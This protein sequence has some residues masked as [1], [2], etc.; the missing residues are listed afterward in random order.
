MAETASRS[1]IDEQI[2]HYIETLLKNRIA[3][4]RLYLFGSRAKGMAQENSDIDLAVFWD[5][6]EIDGFDEDVALMRLTRDV[7]LRIEPHSFSRKDFDNP[8]P[9]V[10]E[11]LA[12]GQRLL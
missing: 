12:T 10:R 1:V 9:F 2:R 6:D 5:R 7:D 4:W 8:D 3:V 11:I